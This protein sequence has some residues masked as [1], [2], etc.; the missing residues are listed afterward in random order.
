MGDILEDIRESYRQGRPDAAA[1]RRKVAAELYELAGEA[2]LPFYELLIIEAQHARSLGDLCTS[3]ALLRRAAFVADQ[4]DDDPRDVR[5]MLEGWYASRPQRTAT[6]V[7]AIDE[8]AIV[9]TVEL[10]CALMQYQPRS[11]E[12]RPWSPSAEIL[13]VFVSSALRGRARLLSEAISEVVRSIVAEA[14]RRL[15]A[16]APADPNYIGITELSAAEISFEKFLRTPPERLFGAPIY[17]SSR[18]FALD[19]IGFFPR[20]HD[21]ALAFALT[22]V[23]QGEGR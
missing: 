13:Y 5:T 19:I 11:M 17:E 14:N 3:E 2:S 4:V 16:S 15:T 6:A 23:D 18:V 7:Q 10:T 22:R 1:L 9:A 12:F 20:A 8:D 21:D